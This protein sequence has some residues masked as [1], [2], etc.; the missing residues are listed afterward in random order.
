VPNT[1]IDD[2]VVVDPVAGCIEFAGQMR[3][4]SPRSLQIFQLLHR[5][6]GEVVTRKTIF[7]EV[8]G[9]H[10]GTDGAL[11]QA[12]AVMRKELGDSISKRV[13]TVPRRGYVFH[14]VPAP[15]NTNILEA[16]EPPSLPAETLDVQAQ[17]ILPTPTKP[18]RAPRFLL[19]ACALL[20]SIIASAFWLRTPNQST[21][22]ALSLVVRPQSSEIA[23]ALESVL[24][25]EFGLGN[26]AP[27]PDAGQ[28][29]IDIDDHLNLTDPTAAISLRW[30]YVSTPT[31][32]L[33]GELQQ[34]TPTLATVLITRLR[35]QLAQLS[36]R[37]PA[38]A[39]EREVQRLRLAATAALNKDDPDIATQALLKLFQAAPTPESATE[40]CWHLRS[41]WRTRTSL[42]YAGWAR[43]KLSSAPDLDL[44]IAD[45]TGRPER[46]YEAARQLPENI[47]S[48]AHRIT[49][50]RRLGRVTLARQELRS[51]QK[52]AKTPGEQTMLRRF[53]GELL[54]TEGRF[55]DANAWF[56]LLSEHDL[57]NDGWGEVYRLQA[58]YAG[59]L[60]VN[61]A[62]II[63]RARDAFVRS[64]ERLGLVDLEAIALLVDLRTPCPLRRAKAALHEA[65]ALA[66]PRVLA[67]MQ[68]STA[69]LL[70]Q[71]GHAQEAA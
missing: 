46:A 63:E 14:A 28:L 35:Q 11:T 68:R 51:A 58:I 2:D 33:S 5:R 38:H 12:I 54:L 59:W 70:Q 7:L 26:D 9:T 69:L 27:P 50:L 30:R 29:E 52:W 3:P 1:K 60:P 61:V 55:Q 40:L 37:T 8:W 22:R 65:E 18:Y 6:A 64:G 21:E 62:P 41:M 53:E 19:L 43:A 66:F 34:T 44:I 71:C 32:K 4:L 39:S 57:G 24:R 47:V 20:V 45:L 25:A 31:R 67:A 42:L 10:T 23:Q 17:A 48:Y 16:S 49:N 56:E 15:D 13:I 36:Q